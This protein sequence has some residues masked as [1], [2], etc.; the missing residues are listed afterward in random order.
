MAERNITLSVVSHRQNALVNHL[1]EDIQRHCADRVALVL[2]EN[3]PDPTPLA[4]GNLSSPVERIANDRVKG[5][6]AN[7]NGAFKHCR[8]P[9]FCVVNPD[10]RLQSDPFSSLLA[11]FDDPAVAVAGPLVRSPAGAAEDSARRFPTAGS[12]LKKFFAETKTPDYPTDRG[13]MEVDWLA[14]MFMLFRSDAYRSAG[15]FDEAYFLYYEDVDICHRLR[16]AGAAVVF[17][18]RAEVIHDARRASRRDAR[19]AL[20]HLSSILRFLRRRGSARRGSGS[21]A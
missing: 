1:L 4:T 2:T 18:P 19:L 5:F 3:I 7:Q 10:I 6:G 21:A 15:G 17:E 14:G 9:W 13:P 12:L 8:T 16:L 11:K 20:H